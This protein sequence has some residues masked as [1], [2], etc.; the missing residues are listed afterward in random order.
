MP[1]ADFRTGGL[2]SLSAAIR[3]GTPRKL[4]RAAT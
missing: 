3:S 2:A 1:Q 4:V